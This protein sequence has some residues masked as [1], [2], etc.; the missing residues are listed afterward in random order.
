MSELGRLVIAVIDEFP[1][2]AKRG[3]FCY[4]G[5]FGSEHSSAIKRTL[6]NK[7]SIGKSA[8]YS[9]AG[10]KIPAFPVYCRVHIRLTSAPLA[11]M[12]SASSLFIGG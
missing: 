12:F 9:V 7:Y 11:I 6:N 8:Y 10:R 2:K 3:L 4:N 5:K 1:G